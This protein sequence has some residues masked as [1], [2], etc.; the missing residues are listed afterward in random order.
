[1]IIR[2]KALSFRKNLADFYLNRQK[3]SLFFDI[4]TTGL[5]WKYSRLY[6][7][8]AAFYQEGQWRLRQWFLENPLEEP[9]LL[10][11]FADFLRNFSSVIH[12]NGQG[13]DLPYLSHKY[14]DYNLSDPL[15]RLE[16]LD[17]YRIFSPWKKVFSLRSLKQKDT[18][19]F[20]GISREDTCGGGELIPV[21]EEYLK[22]ASGDLLELL[23]LH[24]RD[25][26]LGLMN[27]LPLYGYRQLLEG[28][29]TAGQAVFEKGEL[30]LSLSLDWPLPEAFSL[31]QTPLRLEARGSSA[32]I[33]SAAFSGE[34]KH[35]FENWKD[36]YYLP[37]EDCA[38][39]KSVGIYVDKNC[40]QKATAKN[41][42]QKSS[43]IFLPQPRPVFQPA[44][45]ADYGSRPAWFQFHPE[46][47]ENQEEL[48]AYAR[49]I[50]DSL[51]S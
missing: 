41:C 16:S 33:H 43:G 40:R 49:M 37:L 34:M 29:F 25:D 15:S 4:E 42:Y 50:L 13:F 26:V 8:G 21:Y 32:V 14:Q 1:M 47:L 46:F 10:R 23:L 38:V 45:Y 19:K 7:I 28:A 39:H 17:L 44:F 20:L 12:Y 36:Y 18:E 5:S 30:A 2:E 48:S 6:L 22:T 24:N 27:L 11:V 51:F 3:D 35:F 31:E 9:E